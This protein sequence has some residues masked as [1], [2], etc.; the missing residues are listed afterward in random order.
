MTTITQS[1]PVAPGRAR[2]R[3]RHVSEY[4]DLAA[5]VRDSGLMR[6]RYRRYV[7]RCTLQLLAYGIGFAL[8]ALLGPTPWQL[9][10]AAFFG[11]MFTQSA[12]LSHDAA[13]RQIFWSGKRNEW[14]SRIAGN[15]FVGLSYGW[16]MIKHS[17]HHSNPNT[18]GK[19][20]DIAPG[21]LVY[22]PDDRA[23]RS[24]I[25]GLFARHQ[26]WFLLPLLAF[27]GLALQ[28]YAVRAILGRGRMKHRAVEGVLL[29]IRLIG[30]PL[31]VI[32]L[33]GPGWGIAFLAVQAAVFGITMGGSF[34]P[35]HKG[36]PLIDRSAKVDFLRRQVLTSRN[37]SGGRLMD[38]AMGG[39][40]NQVEHH[41]FPSMPSANLRKVKPIVAAYCAER[42]IPVTETNLIASYK[43]VIDYLNQVGLE[44]ADPFDCP[45]M[46]ELR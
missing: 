37:I 41:L 26:G 36:M 23:E 11:V 30:F 16:W 32:M 2:T 33:L 9:L 34:A 42:G 6:R 18:V 21:A 31:L 28:F 38:V 25:A 40:N 12:Y 44:Q 43:I 5:I 45:L 19:D 13:H 4:T 24:G 22:T 27:S 7:L 39:L 46:S 29:G 14:F 8:L 17:R 1:P 3:D 15:F 35:N 10:V 20:D